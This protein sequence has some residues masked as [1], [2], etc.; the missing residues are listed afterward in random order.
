MMTTT[1]LQRGQWH[2]LEGGNNAIA[3]RA[4]TLSQIKGNNAIVMRG[5]QC[6][7]DNNKNA[8]ALTMVT[9]PLS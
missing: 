3:T 5:Q 4:T 8:C 1:P 2:Q 9:T 7:L 6:Q